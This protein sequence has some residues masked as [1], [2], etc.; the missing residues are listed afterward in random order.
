MGAARI[1]VSLRCPARF[2][3]R[4]TC[5]YGFDY[6]PLYLLVLWII[7]SFYAY[8]EKFCYLVLSREGVNPEFRNHKLLFGFQLTTLLYGL[9]AVCILIPSKKRR[10]IAAGERLYFCRWCHDVI[11]GN[12]AHCFTCDTCVQQ[13]FTHSTIF[14]SC[15]GQA[16]VV[17][18]FQFQLYFAFN[19]AYVLLT[20]CNDFGALDMSH[21]SHALVTY[22]LAMTFFV[23]LVVTFYFVINLLYLALNMKPDEPSHWRESLRCERPLENLRKTFG[24]YGFLR[25]LLVPTIPGGE[26]FPKI[27]PLPPSL[28]KYLQ[29]L[30]RHVELCH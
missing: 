12:T 26:T 17:A 8:G 21:L 16:N 20:L 15:I 5:R 9:P 14:N 27:S 30:C 22:Y 11:D 6:A 7:I 25:L 28:C 23:F 19:Q 3:R 10:K 1:P 18:F 13:H 4:L 29:R 24:T 2:F